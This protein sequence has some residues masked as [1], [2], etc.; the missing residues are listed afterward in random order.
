M[1]LEP[2]T[3][4]CSFSFSLL[5]STNEQL[6]YYPEVP[7]CSFDEKFDQFAFGSLLTRREVILA[8]NKVRAECNKVATLCLFQIPVTKSMRLEEFEQTQ[9]QASSQ[10]RSRLCSFPIAQGF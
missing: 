10:V 9:S 6:G 3:F 5:K 2:F 8:M 7:E 1:L 4:F